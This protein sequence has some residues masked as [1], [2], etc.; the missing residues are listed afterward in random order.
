MS[1]GIGLSGR[2]FE[3]GNEI[4]GFIKRVEFLEKLSENNFRKDYTPRCQLLR[5]K[6]LII[7]VFE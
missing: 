4:S 2:I 1:I 3:H 7:E 5:H 6:T